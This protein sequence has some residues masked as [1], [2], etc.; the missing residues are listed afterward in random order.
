MRTLRLLIR[1]IVALLYERFINRA[2]VHLAGIVMGLLLRGFGLLKAR[3]QRRVRCFICNMQEYVAWNARVF[4]F[5]PMFARISLWSR[6]SPCRLG[7]SR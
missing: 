3:V 7:H 4:C 5:E 6:Q 2:G 1:S